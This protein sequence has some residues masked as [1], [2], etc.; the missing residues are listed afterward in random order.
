MSMDF[1]KRLAKPGPLFGMQA[2]AGSPALVEIM[3]HAGLDWVSLDMEHTPWDFERIEHLARAADAAGIA[4]L[5]RVA[6]NDPI[7]IMKALDAGT[8]GVI[9]PHINS[10]A[11]LEQALAAAIHPPHGMRGVCSTVRATKYSFDYGKDFFEKV[12][13]DVVVVPLVEEKSA[14]EAFDE[15]LAVENVPVYWIGISD[16]AASLGIAGADFQHPQRAEIGRDLV[17]R[18]RAAGKDLMCTVAPRITP[19]YADY[20]IGLGFRL[21]S[22]GVDLSFFARSMKD[23]MV[24]LRPEQKPR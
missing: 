11:S 7:L 16:L 13:R 12:R 19:D 15:L 9:V 24:R 21:I 5:V 4:P 6:Q 18:A 22:Y 14:I 17:R 10:R 20:L 23:L 8:A 1:R 3:G 2:F